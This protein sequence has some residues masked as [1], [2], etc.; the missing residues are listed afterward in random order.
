MVSGAA[1]G[2][3]LRTFSAHTG[4]VTA[5]AFSPDGAE[6]LSAD[7]DGHLI[8]WDVAS[9]ELVQ[10]WRLPEGDAA[11]VLNWETRVALGGTRVGRLVMVG[12][13]TLWTAPPQ[14]SAFTALDVHA[15]RIAVGRA[16][17]VICLWTQVRP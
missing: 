12:G 11:T 16:D 2:A 7:A 13:E 10:R 4:A 17:G 14:G 1:N 5:L 9:G 8:L 6:L 3:R 15:N